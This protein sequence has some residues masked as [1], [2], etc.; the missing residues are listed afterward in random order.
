MCQL[1]SLLRG[2]RKGLLLLASGGMVFFSSLVNL[3]IWWGGWAR[4][5]WGM[6]LTISD[7]VLK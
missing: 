1:T 5:D 4:T 7:I 3:L 2:P 6:M